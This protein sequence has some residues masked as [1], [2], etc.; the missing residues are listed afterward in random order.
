MAVGICTTDYSCTTLAVVEVARVVEKLCKGGL[1]VGEWAK[2]AR[3]FIQLDQHV[4]VL[5]GILLFRV[6]E[7]EH[8]LDDHL[9]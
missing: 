8:P 6:I 7:L 9:Y 4:F 3:P 1:V 2:E 5:G